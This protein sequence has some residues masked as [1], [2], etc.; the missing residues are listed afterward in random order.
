MDVALATAGLTRDGVVANLG[1]NALIDITMTATA[2]SL[3]SVTVTADPNAVI[4]KGS[5]IVT[6]SSVPP[7]SMNRCRTRNKFPRILCS[8]SPARRA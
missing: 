8:T 2:V 3:S 4:D 7:P 5:K 6:V 1:A